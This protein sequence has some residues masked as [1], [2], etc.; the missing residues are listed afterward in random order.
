M[1]CNYSEIEVG[2][3]YSHH[4]KITDNLVREFSAI[5]KDNNPIHLD[6]NY[7]TKSI[8]GKRVA[9][10]MLVASFFSTIFGKFFPGKGSI[11]LSHDFNF[12]KPVYIDDRLVYY[13]EVIK[14][15]PKNKLVFTTSCF[16]RS[17]DKEFLVIDGQA[18]LLVPDKG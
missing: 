16:R 4:F 8:F 9:H 1:K 13:V 7:A 3:S 14:K 18:V 6:D 15:L 5:T 12:R 2:Q 11:Y 10:G 17:I